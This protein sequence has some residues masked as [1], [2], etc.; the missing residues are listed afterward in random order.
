MA[1]D[2]WWFFPRSLACTLRRVFRDGAGEICV[3]SLVN[4]RDRWC[5]LSQVTIITP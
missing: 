5:I 4:R 3:T 2:A 1:V